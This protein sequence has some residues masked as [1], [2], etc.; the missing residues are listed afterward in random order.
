VDPAADPYV[1]LARNLEGPELRRSDGAL[2]VRGRLGGRR[3][4][5]R[6]VPGRTGRRE[7]RYWAASPGCGPA[8]L[9]RRGPLARTLGRLRG[10]AS[11]WRLTTEDPT[12]R[13]RLATAETTWA[14]RFLGQ[15]YGV[16]AIRWVHGGVAASEEVRTTLAARRG[17]TRVLGLLATL[18][19]LGRLGASPLAVAVRPA[20]ERRAGR[21]GRCPFCHECQPHPSSR[22]R[23]WS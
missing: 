5:V 12:A 14:A 17:T 13:A 9:R 16:T 23:T 1:D 11:G 22:R 15:A 21:A 18:V 19:R 3:V 2:T 4:C 8:V 20:P 10:D 7:V 6:V